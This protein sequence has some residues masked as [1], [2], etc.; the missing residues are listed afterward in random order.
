MDG[1]YAHVSTGEI[2]DAWT[3]Q[4][5]ALTENSRH[6]VQID[7]KGGRPVRSYSRYGLGYPN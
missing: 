5:V 3:R 4:V 2:V 7:W 6:F 1:R